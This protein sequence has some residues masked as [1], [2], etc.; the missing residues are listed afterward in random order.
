MPG[1]PRIRC[2]NCGGLFVDPL[3]TGFIGF[4]GSDKRRLCGNCTAR[5]VGLKPST[6]AA[7]WSTIR[8]M[9]EADRR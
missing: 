9:Q 5:A 6:D 4:P 7:K 8:A 3:P 2:S 1:K